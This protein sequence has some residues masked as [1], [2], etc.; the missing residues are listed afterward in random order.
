M[1]VISEKIGALG[2]QIVHFAHFIA[3]SAESGIPVLFPGFHEFAPY[4]AGS[5]AG[6][7]P[8]YPTPV[9]SQL[10]TGEL[11]YRIIQKI[12]RLVPHQGP[13]SVMESGWENEDLGSAAFLQK[14]KVTKILFAR[15]YGFR[16]KPLVEKHAD[17]LK[18]YFTPVDS[19]F[20]SINTF[21]A[22]HL[23]TEK[24]TVGVHIRHGDYRHWDGG[25]Y[26]FETDSYVRIMKRYQELKGE[27]CRFL[28]AS[29]EP[30]PIEAFAGLDVVMAPGHYIHDLYLLAKCSA[31]IGPPS[32]YST[33]SSFFG[34]VPLLRLKETNPPFSLADFKVWKSA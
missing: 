32:S 3:F 6:R 34:N 21:A 24:P 33:W 26:F 16:S 22:K 15:G 10:K 30:Q 9:T 7:I 31:I 18:S 23:A 5:F 4:F 20:Q 27:P 11:T 17:I 12:S 28:I 19:H 25:K 2:N 29:N 14:A 13:L 1:I 8:S